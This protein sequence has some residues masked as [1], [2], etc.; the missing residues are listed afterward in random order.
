MPWMFKIPGDAYAGE[1]PGAETEEEAR[2]FLRQWLKVKRV[3]RGTQF[4]RND[5]GWARR[6]AENNR[7]IGIRADND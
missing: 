1:A 3:P 7:R 5:P 2:E 4:W 6:M